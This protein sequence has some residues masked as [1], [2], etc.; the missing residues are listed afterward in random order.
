MSHSLSTGLLGS[1]VARLVVRAD[2]TIDELRLELIAA[3]PRRSENK[4]ALAV[5]D[6]V[7]NALLLVRSLLAL[8]CVPEVL[9]LRRSAWMNS[10][11]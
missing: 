1:S 2:S 8:R 9:V 11:D 5:A 3:I 6:K 10:R 7:K 4:K